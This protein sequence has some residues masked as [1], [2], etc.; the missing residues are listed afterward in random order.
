M[1]RVMAVT[2]IESVSNRLIKNLSKGYQQ[3]VG[4]AQALLGTRRW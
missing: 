2:Q 3:R 1:R 4:I